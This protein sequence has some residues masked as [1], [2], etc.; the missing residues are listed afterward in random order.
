MFLSLPKFYLLDN[1]GFNT[2]IG[3]FTMSLLIIF[4]YTN[5]LNLFHYSRDSQY[6]EESNKRE[7]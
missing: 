7:G 2:E 1:F 4:F 5:K 3:I 6:K